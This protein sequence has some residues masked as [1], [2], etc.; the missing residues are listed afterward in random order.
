[1]L[2][3]DS[4]V[5]V[6]DFHSFNWPL[7]II[8]K[9]YLNK[10]EKIYILGDSTD[11]GLNNKG[12]NGIKLLLSIME[13]CNTYKNR[14]IYVPGNHD[15]LL[16]KYSISKINK[17]YHKLNLIINGGTNTCKD[18][19][20]LK[21]D[22]NILYNKLI[23]WL[24]TLPIQRVHIKNN[25]RYVIA[26]ALFN[27]KLYQKNKNFSL[28]DYINTNNIFIKRIVNN[29]LWFR[30]YDNEL[31]KYNKYE[32]PTSDNIMIIGHTPIDYRK[33]LNLDL[34]GSDNKYIKVICVDGGI[35]LHKE[36]NK[37][38]SFDGNINNIYIK[39]PT[40]KHIDKELIKKTIAI[41]GAI[42]VLLIGTITKLNN[43]NKSNNYIKY[44][45]QNNDTL[46]NISNRYNVS[47]N[48]ILINNP[49]IKENNL[50]PGQ[51]IYIPKNKTKKL[52]KKY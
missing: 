45:I 31:N 27:E 18:I 52:V 5:V 42:S 17:Y 50:I 12:T 21:N 33:N 30:K 13:L 44:T 38:L 23:N 4:F 37:L 11:R 29:I 24:E 48:E 39:R 3:K 36:S 16:Y 1:M 34:I 20:K 47:T 19:D 14:I 7:E 2:E 46:I 10:Y 6:S 25:Q 49:N 51:T 35:P 26:H 28:K 32:L 9:E 8:K 22:N 40:K 15:L 41:I 43:K